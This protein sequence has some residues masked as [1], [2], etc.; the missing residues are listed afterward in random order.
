MICDK[1]KFFRAACSERWKEGQEKV[2][3][4]P[5]VQSEVFQRYV[6]WAYCDA[7]TQEATASQEV[8]MSVELYLLGDLLDNVKLRNATVKAILQHLGKDRLHPGPRNAQLVWEKTLPTSPIRRLMIDAIVLRSSHK[9]FEEKI[10]EWPV[11]MVRRVAVKLT[12]L[13]AYVRSSTVLDHSSKYLEVED[14]D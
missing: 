13:G 5:E 2:I 7:L 1:S 12:H 11:D 9:C 4:L 6:D 3:R 10:E 8:N 14:S